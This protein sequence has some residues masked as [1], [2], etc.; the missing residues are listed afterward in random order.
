MKMLPVL[1]LVLLLMLPHVVLS[2]TGERAFAGVGIDGV[3]CADGQIRVGQLVYG[4]PAHL[5]GIRVG[6][7]IT[8]IDGVATRGTDFGTVV[9]MRLRGPPGSPVVIRIQRKGL[10]KPLTFTIIRRQI[11]VKP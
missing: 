6:D 4:G 10:E 9:R 11:V 3:A 7:I 8:H 2:A 1:F 5:A